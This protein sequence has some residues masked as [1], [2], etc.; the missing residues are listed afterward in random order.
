M[1]TAVDCIS[2]KSVDSS[3]ASMSLSLNLTNFNSA[4]GAVGSNPRED[5]RKGFF[6]VDT[7]LPGRSGAVAD[8]MTEIEDRIENFLEAESVNY[9]NLSEYLK[10]LSIYE[11]KQKCQ[12]SL[13]LRTSQKKEEEQK[14]LKA[15]VMAKPTVRLPYA[16]VS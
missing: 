9:I 7:R 13:K 14:E 10:A 15:D 11:E 6:D 8:P 1:S 4:F 2:K 12:A 5:L 16:K 3:P